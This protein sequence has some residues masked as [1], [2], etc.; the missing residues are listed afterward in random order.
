MESLLQEIVKN[1]E[2]KSSFQSVLSRNKT[3]FKTRFNPTI[4]LSK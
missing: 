1:T 3:S 4:Q 2:P